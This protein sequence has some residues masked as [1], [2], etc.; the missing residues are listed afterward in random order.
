MAKKKITNS[1]IIKPATKI[2]KPTKGLVQIPQP[3][4]ENLKLAN[5][6][7]DAIG[8]SG[9]GFGFGG[10]NG[11]PGGATFQQVEDS[12]TMFQFLRWYMVS[13]FRQLISQIFVEIGLIQTIVCV[14]VD[15]GLRGGVE[16]KSKQLDEEELKR[17]QTRMKR[18]DDI[19]KAGWAAK[20]NRLYGGAGLLILVDDQDPEMPLDISKINK[21]TNM[22]LRAVDMW[23]LFWDKQ[24]TEGY[25]P[26]TQ[27]EDFEYYN[28]YAEQVHKS[29]VMR[30]VG[31]EA[32]SFVRPRFRGW[33]V[34]V[35]EALVSSINN[36]LKAT[37]L[38]FEVLDEFKLDVY[39]IKNLV[40]TL[41]S[42]DGTT[43]VKTRIQLAN[44]Q[45]NYQHAIVMDS[46]DDFDHK[47]L[48]F[49]GLAEAM[50]QIRMQVAAD[51]RMPIIKLFG[52]S[53]SKG[54]GSTAEDEMENY[55]S[56]VEAEV[57]N[58][59]E[60]HL[61]RIF[62]LRCQQELGFIPDDLELEFKPLRELT[63][64]EQETVK[65]EKF[66][67]AFQM[68]QGG[69]ISI[70][71]FEEICNKGNLTDVK[72]DS[73]G[74][75]VLVSSDSDS[76]EEGEDGPSEGDD[77]GPNQEYSRQ[78]H[79]QDEHDKKAAQK[80]KMKNSPT[81]DRKSYEADGGDGWIN[82]KRKEFFSNPGNVDE[83][84]WAKAKEASMKSFGKEKWQ[85]V[86]WWY[87]KQG[88]KFS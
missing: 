36:Y 69:I 63:A 8:F 20:W 82:P 17:V 10:Q 30:L 87:K 70:E 4:P 37:S 51:M 62:E 57:R 1:K 64:T 5:S 25:D 26:E 6:F 58:K 52:T 48:S 49:S 16:F 67:R 2:I 28:Y 33:G 68:V 14:P 35:V 73:A 42:A 31:M 81:F 29:R 34:S 65:T 60:Y 27:D 75:G 61:L 43:S 47:Q 7:S 38:G 46:E 53:V 44:W 21:N 15:D 39:K 79:V 78:V 88:G 77:A 85:F 40:N 50:E 18:E 59:L 72:L 80:S 71:K 19:G 56:M 3:T 13:N 45:K 54:M 11:F 22:Q 32:P 76:A 66:N 83:G 84:L 74:R 23:E 55:N 24:N 9:G 12:S 86:T 41:L